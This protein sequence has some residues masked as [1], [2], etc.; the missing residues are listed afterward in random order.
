MRYIQGDSTVM[1]ALLLS[2]LNGVFIQILIFGIFKY[3]WWLLY[4]MY[5]FQSTLFIFRTISG[6]SCDGDKDFFQIL[7]YFFILYVFLNII[8]A[9]GFWRNR[10]NIILHA[11]QQTI[12]SCR[13]QT[14][15]SYYNFFLKKLRVSMH[16]YGIVFEI[17]ITTRAPL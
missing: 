9:I 7:I 8:I 16:F 3:I 17:Q 1:L 14:N 15:R 12:L 13:H 4:Y 6:V 11:L 2:S 10:Y 5:I